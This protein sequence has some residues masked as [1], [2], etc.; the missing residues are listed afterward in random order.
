MEGKVARKLFIVTATKDF[1]FYF[2]HFSPQRSLKKIEQDMPHLKYH[3]RFG[4]RPQ[5]LQV[6]E[7]FVY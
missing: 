4:C 3:R 6:R 2:Y 7:P 1:G 5:N